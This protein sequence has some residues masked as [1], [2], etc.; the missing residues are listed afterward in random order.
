[1]DNETLNTWIAKQE[2]TEILHRYARGCDRLDEAALR[3]CFHPDSTHEHGAFKGRS[4]DFIDFAVGFIRKLRDCSHLVTNVLIEIEGAL[5][6]SECHYV[7]HHRRYQEGTTREEDFFAKGR[8][9]DRF[10]RR[11]GV[12]KIAHR[13]GI[14]D[15]THVVAIPDALQGARPAGVLSARKPDDPLYHMLAGLKG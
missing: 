8:Y 15:L 14:H 2:I 12:W 6:V 13:T 3:A 5:A 4:S 7:A 9:L 10:E 11:A 1:M